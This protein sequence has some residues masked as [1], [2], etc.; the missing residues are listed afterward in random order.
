MTNTSMGHTLLDA[1]GIA[2]CIAVSRYLALA[3][4]SARPAQSAAD[5]ITG[6]KPFDSSSLA[7]AAAD[8]KGCK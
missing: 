8:P 2:F 4:L 7:R 3:L 5:T 6:L 1:D